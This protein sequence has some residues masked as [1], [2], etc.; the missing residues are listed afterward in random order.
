[1][2]GAVDTAPNSRHQHDLPL[3]SSVTRTLALVD[4][5]VDAWGTTVESDGKTVW[6]EISG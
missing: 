5:L 2:P 3:G 4:G 6:A 1:M